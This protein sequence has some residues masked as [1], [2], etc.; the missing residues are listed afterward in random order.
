MRNTFVLLRTKAVKLKIAISAVAFVLS[1]NVH[2]AV[3]TW[4]STAVTNAQAD[5]VAFIELIGPAVAAVAIGFLLIKIF[6]RG[7]NKI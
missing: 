3:P 1:T 4:A 6:K 7:T 2:A 5:G